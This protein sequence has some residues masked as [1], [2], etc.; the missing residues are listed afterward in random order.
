MPG[1]AKKSV[2]K[3]KASATKR[4]T[5]AQRRAEEAERKR[6][7]EE[8]WRSWERRL[9]SLAVSL[10]CVAGIV[11]ELFFEENPREAVLVFLGTILGLP[12]VIS[13]AKKVGEG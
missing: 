13:G 4:K 8:R 9:T 7:E 6:E 12:V 11:N 5:A 2:A 3:K 1:V 10:V